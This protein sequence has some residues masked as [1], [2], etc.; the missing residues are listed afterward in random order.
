VPARGFAPL[1][2]VARDFVPVEFAGPRGTGGG[3]DG[4]A[5]GLPPLAPPPFVIAEPDEDWSTR[6]S[7]FGETEA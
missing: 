3:D 5:T 4:P 2:H 1:E 7:L 6:T